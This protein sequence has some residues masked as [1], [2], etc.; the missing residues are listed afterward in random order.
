[1]AGRAHVARGIW[2]VILARPEK[3]CLRFLQRLAVTDTPHLF[4]HSCYL[5]ARVEG[6]RAGA[7][8]GYDP[9][10]HGNEALLRAIA[11]FADGAG[12]AGPDPGAEERSRKV[13]PC[14]P[15]AV[16]GAWVIDSVATLPGFR[17]RGVA[18][19]LLKAALKEGRRRG[20]GKAQINMYIGN[21]AAKRLYEKHGFRVSD[22]RRSPDFEA[23]VGS[24]GM[25]SLLREI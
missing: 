25:L 11:E 3:D 19:A 18:D 24:P 1:M 17:R 16:E 4:H 13:L 7:L 9:R 2:E 20:F 21:E 10:T 6:E 14:I 5:V 12:T 23:Q 22:E 15:D 8:G